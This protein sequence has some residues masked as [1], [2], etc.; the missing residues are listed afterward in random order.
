MP[1][2]G[3][4]EIPAQLI[5]DWSSTMGDCPEEWGTRPKFGFI[6]TPNRGFAEGLKH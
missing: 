1:T 5:H 4:C 6:Y 2:K 3:P